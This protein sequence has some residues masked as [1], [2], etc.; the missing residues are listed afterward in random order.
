MPID[1]SNIAVIIPYYFIP[2][3]N[4]GHHAAFGFCEALAKQCNLVVISTTNNQTTNLPFR[5]E[6][7]FAD[8]FFKYFSPIVAWRLWRLFKQEQIATCI[9]QQPFIGLITL[10]VCRLLGIRLIVYIHNIEF[11]R[12]KTIGA[13]WW[14]IL[15]FMEWF[16]YRSADHL[17]FISPDDLDEAIPIFRLSPEKCTVVPYG[18]RLIA[19]PNDRE[20]ARKVIINR[21]E[22][23]EN[24]FVILF[25]GPQSYRPNLEA[26]ERI[27][28]HINPI[29]Q[30][31][32]KFPYRILI[33]GGGLPKH[34]NNLA[35]YVDQHID[36]LGFVKDIETYI[37]A[38][39]IVINPI[40]T[41]GGVKTKIIEA[42][43]LGT[44]VVSTHTGAKGVDFEA[45]GEKLARTDDE[46]YDSFAA[47]IVAFQK[48]GGKNT[49]ASFYEIYNWEKIINRLIPIPP[50]P[51]Q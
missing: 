31:K 20:E 45:C 38:A 18:T 22:L 4:G 25:F 27:I 21:H 10:P 33:C 35:K 46:D 42:I 3:K 51:I 39:D 32:A 37:K 17:F 14:R 23:T 47:T 24:E 34:Y 6:Q 16:I 13:W 28:H 48:G 49:P 7:L 2:P 19:P 50:K 43:A 12:F 26:V 11:Q 15:Y 5:L 8:R 9:I 41:G 44:T 30:E 36:Y 29:L 40:T 1:A